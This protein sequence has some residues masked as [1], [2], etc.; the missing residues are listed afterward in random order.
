MSGE[1][2]FSETMRKG[3][4]SHSQISASSAIICLA[5]ECVTGVAESTKI[6]K[7][8]RTPYWA[9]STN[10]ERVTPTSSTCGM[11]RE[12]RSNILW[13]LAAVRK[14]YHDL[15]GAVAPRL[16]TPVYFRLNVIPQIQPLKILWHIRHVFAK[17]RRWNS[18][19]RPNIF[20]AILSSAFANYAHEWVGVS[21]RVINVY[22]LSFFN[23]SKRYK[24]FRPS[25]RGVGVAGVVYVT[26]RGSARIKPGIFA[27][28]DPVLYR[29]C[30]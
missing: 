4:V 8:P 23:I 25:N 18:I 26:E 2:T 22:F 20:S 11:N 13:A 29:H 16:T 15:A 19:D 5:S 27:G 28:T 3:A 21:H 6:S 9:N 10:I 17:N 30:V 12:N 7:F 14:Q 1:N 24:C